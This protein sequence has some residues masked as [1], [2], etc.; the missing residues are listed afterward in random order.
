MSSKKAEEFT[1]C[2]E[3]IL[4]L[5][6]SSLVLCKDGRVG[7]RK[8]KGRD[9]FGWHLGDEPGVIKKAFL[10]MLRGFLMNRQASGSVVW[11]CGS[12]GGMNRVALSRWDQHPKCGK[13]QRV[14]E[15]GKPQALGDGSFDTVVK[16]S[17]LPVLVD[18]WAPWCGPCRMLT[19]V[20]EKVASS[21]DGELVVAKVNSDEAPGVSARFGIRAIP[22]ML[23][24][25]NGKEIARQAGFLP[26]PQLKRWLQR[27]LD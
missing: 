25:R 3:V 23:L 16:N 12:C 17:A 18:F 14:L 13:C 7:W 9:A 2:Y 21:Y 19:P 5:L 8:K 20:L 1:F 4:P 24:M 26:E 15:T 11:R 22:T 6:D 27:Y 10:M